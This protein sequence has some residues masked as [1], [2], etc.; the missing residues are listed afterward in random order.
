M[1]QIL[2]K[3]NRKFIIRTKEALNLL[4]ERGKK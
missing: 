1:G 3:G 2:I 4:K